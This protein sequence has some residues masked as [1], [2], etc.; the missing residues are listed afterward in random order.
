M[1]YRKNLGLILICSISLILTGCAGV[2][3]KSRSLF[4]KGVHGKKVDSF[5]F[6]GEEITPEKEKQLLA[7]NTI[8]F[9]YDKDNIE[10]NY[11]LVLLAHAKKMLEE[12][13]LKLRI[14]G[15]TDE[16][17]SAEYNIGLGERRAKSV[18]RFLELKGISS[19]KLVNVSYGKEKPV[20]VGHNEEA[21]SLNRRAELVYE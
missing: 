3:G 8:Y 5:A 6:Y 13:Y 11:K 21:W 16:R 15:H 12:P 20:A 2:D 18:V 7:E 4:R 17:G 19:D 1:M 9:G 10:E 14:D